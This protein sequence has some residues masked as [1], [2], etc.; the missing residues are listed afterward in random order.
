MKM[1]HIFQ[2]D[3]GGPLICWKNNEW[4][5]T[6]IVSWGNTVCASQSLPGVYSKVS[7]YRYWIDEQVAK[8]I[9]FVIAF[10]RLKKK[11]ETIV[12]LKKIF[13]LDGK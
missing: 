7:Y 10:L 8:V 9:N 6:G 2:G 3:S 4:K 11:K 13:Y 12:M 5:V 1:W